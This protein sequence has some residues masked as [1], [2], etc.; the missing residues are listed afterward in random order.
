MNHKTITVSRRCDRKRISSAPRKH[1]VGSDTQRVI[2]K[3][4]SRTA[5]P[6]ASS[7][8]KLIHINVGNYIVRWSDKVHVTFLPLLITAFKSLASRRKRSFHRIENDALA[9]A[10]R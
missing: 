2:I 4:T 9:S 1:M 5:E 7:L 8:E 10:G 6:L 3:N